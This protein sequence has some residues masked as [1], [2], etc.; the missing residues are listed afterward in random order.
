MRYAIDIKPTYYQSIT[1]T[2]EDLKD[3]NEKYNFNILPQTSTVYWWRDKPEDID[4]TIASCQCA[5]WREIIYQMQKDYRKFN[6]LDDF[7]LKVARAN[8]KHYPTGKTGY[9]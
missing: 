5:D 9:E 7:A 8:P 2:A 3:Y 1:V 6:H 4:E